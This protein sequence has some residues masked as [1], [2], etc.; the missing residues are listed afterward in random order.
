MEK[1]VIINSKEYKIPEISFKAIC[2]IEELGVDFSK[3]SSLKFISGLAAYTMGVDLDTAMNEIEQHIANGGS[4]DS[5]TVLSEAVLESSFFQQ[6][7]KKKK[8]NKK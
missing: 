7:T 5:L 8:A 1:S 4:L 3:M 6:M 2:E